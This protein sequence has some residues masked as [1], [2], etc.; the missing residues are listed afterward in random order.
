[1]LREPEFGRRLDELGGTVVGGTPLAYGK[2][3]QDGTAKWREVIR[4]THIP[5][6]L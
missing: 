4:Q 5:P 3:L 6:P 2:K 1:V